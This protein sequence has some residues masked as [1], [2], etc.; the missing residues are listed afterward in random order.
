MR[1][2]QPQ[3]IRKTDERKV[4]LE[5]GRDEQ[6]VAKT[7][8]WDEDRSSSKATS[9][10]SPWVR[11]P[12]C[13]PSLARAAPLKVTRM[14]CQLQAGEEPRIA[15]GINGTE[16]DFLM[17]RQVPSGVASM[18]GEGPHRWRTSK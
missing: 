7:V 2:R 16:G 5:V 12:C 4:V 1:K 3:I 13:T 6:F 18:S 15:I 8:R 14:A 9:S 11:L 10:R 17:G